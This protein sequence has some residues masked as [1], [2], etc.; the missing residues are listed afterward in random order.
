MI[1]I[2][3]RIQEVKDFRRIAQTYEEV[4][5]LR[6][7]KIKDY[8]I[9]S[10]EFLSGLAGVYARV[11][12]SYTEAIKDLLQAKGIKNPADQQDYIEKMN[13]EKKN[14]KD[15]LVFLSAN[16][17]LYGEIIKKVFDYFCAQ[18]DPTVDIAIIGRLGKLWF[19]QRFP[20]KNYIYFDLPDNIQDA[21]DVSG[22]V[23]KLSEYEHIIVYHGKFKDVLEQVPSQTA[24]SGERLAIE[25]K[26]D[27]SRMRC[28]FEPSLEEVFSFFEAEIKSVLFD[29]ALY[30]ASLSKYT[31]RMVSLDMATS[32]AGERLKKL[33]LQR[34]IL[35]HRQADKEKNTI[36]ASVMFG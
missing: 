31:S 2:D 8:V 14:G 27:L 25:T 35:K 15:V 18:I 29:Q 4:A 30:E 9:H 34:D 7:R 24:V 20:G 21:T 3:R 17:G 6:M 5:A 11:K 16:T 22:I 12:I 23:S 32:N 28:I 10:R 33:K 36:L 13:F 1:K 19:E 26:E